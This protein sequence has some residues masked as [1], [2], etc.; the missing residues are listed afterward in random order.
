[1][2]V[3]VCTVCSALLIHLLQQVLPVVHD[4]IIDISASAVSS[5]GLSVEP[6]L[7]APILLAF[8]LALI[9]GAAFK[10]AMKK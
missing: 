9:W 10:V 2:A 7:V 1:L 6:T 4:K 3:L 5:L 8:V